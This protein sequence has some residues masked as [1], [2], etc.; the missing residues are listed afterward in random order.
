MG[1]GSEQESASTPPRTTFL[2]PAGAVVQNL[3]GVGVRPQSGGFT[4]AAGPNDRG[5]GLRSTA[6]GSKA[7]PSADEL[8][9]T[10][11][12]GF[13]TRGF[14]PESFSS[15]GD[16]AFQTNPAAGLGAAGLLGSAEGF[17]SGQDLLQSHTLP[18]LRS[19]LDTG[20]PTDVDAIVQRSVADIA[21]TLVPSVGLFSTDLADQ[22]TRTA[23][24]LRVGA[25]E[26]AK[27]R[28]ME[29]IPLSS[30]IASASTQLPTQFGGEALEL[31]RG[32]IEEGT[33]GGV[34]A[35]LLERFL[36]A[37]PTGAIPRGNVSDST[38]KSTNVF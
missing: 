5:S 30:L 14:G 1:G 23:A 33:L 7:D 35:S 22:A 21:E 25:S 4:I 27:R 28:Q 32:L 15:V 16:L 20:N 38:G 3:F 17:L 18:A 29:A 10:P 2:N 13:A 24:E 36:G 11:E 31:G 26:E 8:S 34:Q 12:G 37:Q 9:T 19:F 6:P